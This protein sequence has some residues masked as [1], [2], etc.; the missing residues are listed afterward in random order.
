VRGLRKSG[1]RAAELSLLLI[2]V[3][4]ALEH[5]PYSG[6]CTMPRGNKPPA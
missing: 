4:N 5:A 6:A 2:A 1:A 3:L